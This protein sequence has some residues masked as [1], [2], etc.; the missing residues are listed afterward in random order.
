MT[1]VKEKV[2][3]VLKYAWTLF[4]FSI[5]SLIIYSCAGAIMMMLT[6]KEDVALTWD[7][8]KLLWTVLGWVLAIG[9]NVAAAYSQG[10]VG[11]DMLASGNM[12]RRAEDR[13]SALKISKYDELQEYRPWKGFVIG[14]MSG[15]I[16]LVFGLLFGKN[17]AVINSVFDQSSANVEKNIGIL[18]LCGFIFSGLTLLPTFYLNGAGVAINYYVTIVA[19]IVP[20]IVTG[21]AYIGG[22]YGKRNK[23][24]RAQD[25]PRAELE[26]KQNKQS[27]V[28]YGALP[29]TK[30]KKRK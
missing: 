17:T 29:G 21:F 4:K 26:A 22:A 25:K 12:Q 1:T 13:G 2:K 16:M 19:V 3:L 18:V 11:Y 5:P 14:A 24:L 8:N 28:N 6:M 27:K 10:I 30:P 23:V 15:I 20:I 9:Y 7:N